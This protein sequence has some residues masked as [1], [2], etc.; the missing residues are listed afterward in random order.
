MRTVI[1]GSVSPKYIEALYDHQKKFLESITM[2]PE[3]ADWVRKQYPFEES[4]YKR[5]E[6]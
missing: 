5:K 3:K 2:D 6:T 4:Y 1:P